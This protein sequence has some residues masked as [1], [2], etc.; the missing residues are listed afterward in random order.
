MIAL[1][2]T[3][4][5]KIKYRVYFIAQLTNYSTVQFVQLLCKF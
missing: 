3:L 5:K 4:G 1:L 2:L